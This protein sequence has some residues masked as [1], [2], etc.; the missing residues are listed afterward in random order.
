MQMDIGFWGD[1]SCVA[2]QGFI[3]GSHHRIQG[4]GNGR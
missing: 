3:R 4:V 1:L 2:V